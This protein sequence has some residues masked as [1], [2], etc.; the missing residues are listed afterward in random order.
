MM[1]VLNCGLGAALGF[2]II[3]FVRSGFPPDFSTASR[4]RFCSG[5]SFVSV[6]HSMNSTALGFFFI[7]LRLILL[8][9]RPRFHFWARPLKLGCGYSRV[10][11]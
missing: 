4:I 1:I 8:R 10:Y 9:E 7:L 2:L 11:F 5:V 3:D 6:T